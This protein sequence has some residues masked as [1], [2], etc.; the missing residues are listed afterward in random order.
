M[1]ADLAA[2]APPTVSAVDLDAQPEVVRR[3]SAAD[4]E[5]AVEA[6]KEHV[7]A[8]DVFQVVLSQRFE[9]K[10]DVDALDLYRVLRHSNPSPYMY[11]LRFAGIES[12]YDVVGSSPEALVTVTG[13]RAV[14]HPPAGTRPRGATPEEDTARAEELRADPKER[15]EHV[16]L[17]D[18]ARNDLGRV[19]V[20]G[21]VDVSGFMRVERY[22]HVMHLVSTVFGRLIPGRT[23]FDVL[24]ATFPAGTVSGAPEAARDGGHRGARAAPPQPVRRDRRLLRRR[25]RHGHGHRDPHRGA[26]RRQRVRAGRCRHRRRQRPRRRAARV[27]GQGRGGAARGRRGRDGADR[28][29]EARAG[30]GRPALPGRC[31]RRAGRGRP[32]VAHRPGRAARPAARDPGVA[33]RHR[34]RA[35]G[36]GPRPRRAGRGARAG[37][38]S[39]P[40]SRRGR[41]A[42]AAVRRRGGLQLRAGRPRRRRRPRR[43]GPHRLAAA[44]AARRAAAGRRRAADRGARPPLERPGP[45]VRAACSR[46]RP[47]A[48]GAR[49]VGA[50]DRGEDPPGRWTPRGTSVA[51][52]RAARPGPGED[53]R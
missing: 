51:V 37:R 46:R 2:P 32:A 27:R 7:R 12:P 5:A 29:R 35:A 49:A 36:A 47:P 38:H 24:R 48:G 21:T 25:R 22:S 20:P 3:T 16:M 13:D 42:A 44:R 8:G 50:L 15:A 11:L 52:R 33:R 18:L 43:P 6:A 31:L 28:S 17:V 40:R 4:Y 19:C 9:V 10:T 23:A 53:R 26:A 34:P 39:R 45:P 41:R 14:V 1:T 30:A